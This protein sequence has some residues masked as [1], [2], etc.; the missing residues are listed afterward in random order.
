M[1]VLEWREIR[2]QNER[3]ATLFMHEPPKKVTE[4]DGIKCCKAQVE[5]PCSAEQAFSYVSLPDLVERRRW[6]TDLIDLQPLE[7]ISP[8]IELIYQSYKAPFPITSRDFVALRCRDRDPATGVLYSYGKSV[9]SS[10]APLPSQTRCVRATAT[11]AF[12]FIPLSENRCKIIRLAK[13]DPK[14]MIP[15]FA[16]SIALN[17]AAESMAMLCKAIERFNPSNIPPLERFWEVALSSSSSPPSPD[18]SSE[19]E[20]D[21]GDS[22]A[23]HLHLKGSEEP[24]QDFEDRS[25]GEMVDDSTFFECSSM[26]LDE[27]QLTKSLKE[28]ILNPLQSDI[29]GMGSHV[30]D[31]NKKLVQL[32]KSVQKLQKQISEMDGSTLHSRNSNVNGGKVSIQSPENPSSYVLALKWAFIVGWPI[33]VCIGYELLWRR[34][35][36]GK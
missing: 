16:V 8:R 6:D 17:K 35:R 20:D 22:S 18:G 11:S 25:V 3:N 15:K 5:L 9:N 10:K 29:S 26:L 13:T 1:I 27:K 30:N 23:I 2:V 34:R 33:G 21:E 28:I 14:G 19:E 4:D 31:Q 24:R 36:G 32:Q 7:T 12:V